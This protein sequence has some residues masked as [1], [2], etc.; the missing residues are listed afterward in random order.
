MI[1]PTFDAVYIDNRVFIFK[2]YRDYF[3]DRG[4]PIETPALVRLYEMLARLKPSLLFQ[5]PCYFHFIFVGFPNHDPRL[6]M[7]RKVKV[8]GA[9]QLPWRT[10]LRQYVLKLRKRKSQKN[11][12]PVWLNM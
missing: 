10:H 2:L 5:E 1:H 12:A 4:V 3:R 8:R 7:A 11:A 6:S 9:P